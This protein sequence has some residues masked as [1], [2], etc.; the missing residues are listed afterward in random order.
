MMGNSARWSYSVSN[1]FP[2]R[3]RVV[4]VVNLRGIGNPAPTPPYV[5]KLQAVWRTA[6]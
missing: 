1:F 4:Q 6:V 2:A 3:I 5:L